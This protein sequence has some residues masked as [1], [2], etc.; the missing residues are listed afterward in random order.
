MATVKFYNTNPV[1]TSYTDYYP[2]GYPMPNRNWSGTDYRFGFNGQEKD[3][4]IYGEGKSYTAEFWQYDSRLG[5]RWNLDPVQKPNE[6]PYATFA[7]NPIWFTDIVG[8]DTSF[9]NDNQARQDFLKAYNT[10]NTTIS[11]LES[12][13]QGYQNQLSSGTLNKHETRATKNAK[14]EAEANLTE[15]NKLK[16]DFTYILTSKVVFHYNS[17]TKELKKN[18]N[19]KITSGHITGSGTEMTGD[20]Y[21]SIRPG[22]DD[23]VI[24]EGRHCNQALQRTNHRPVLEIEREAFLYQKI[25]NAQGV[26]DL[27]EN[28][29]ILEYKDPTSKY[30]D[31]NNRPLFYDLDDAIKYI[32]K[33]LIESENKK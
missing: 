16:S 6:S 28:A 4:E 20:V 23:Y 32:Y 11:D 33:D 9:G 5:R 2:F 7:N 14:A 1:V 22:Y 8:K 3:N 15:W 19:G 29:R 21:I 31:P 13:I 10:V 24:H 25:Y 18:E 26:Y 30:S 12:E 17:D 27:I